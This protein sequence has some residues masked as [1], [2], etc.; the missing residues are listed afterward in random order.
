M[1]ITPIRPPHTGPHSSLYAAEMVK[2]VLL[3]IQ[4]I[5]ARIAER[6]DA[7]DA[8]EHT[9]LQRRGRI[10]GAMVPIDWYRKA[11]EKMGE[12]TEF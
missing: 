7:L 5:R 4:E 10:V 8:A 6:V 11:S 3:G 1:T 9:V 2:R 12:P